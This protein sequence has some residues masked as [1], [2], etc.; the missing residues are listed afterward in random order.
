MSQIN[1]KFKKTR[2]KPRQTQPTIYTKAYSSCIN[3]LFNPAKSFYVAIALLPIELILNLFIV[4]KVKCNWL[5]LEHISHSLNYLIFFFKK[6][7]RHRNRLDCVY[8][9]SIFGIPAFCCLLVNIQ[10][11]N[12]L[13]LCFKEVEGFLN[14]TFN[15]Y[16][17]R[18][19][20]GPLV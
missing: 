6:F 19:D 12:N 9:R 3:L 13:Q 17:L 20:T 14:G 15:Y 10:T 18:G 2:K 7:N 4:F 1:Y 8:A 16:E 11:I 5:F